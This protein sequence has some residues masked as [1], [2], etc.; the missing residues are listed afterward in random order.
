MKFK[1]KKKY[2]NMKM[3]DFL[4]EINKFIPN[5]IFPNYSGK[6]FL[7]DLKDYP[8]SNEICYR[9]LLKYPNESY[10][11]FFKISRGYPR[12]G[13]DDPQIKFIFDLFSKGSLMLYFENLF[14][15]LIS[16][17]RQPHPKEE[18]LIN[19]LKILSEK[20]VTDWDRIVSELG[21]CCYEFFCKEPEL[22]LDINDQ[23]EDDISK[24]NDFQLLQKTNFQF[25]LSLKEYPGHITRKSSR[26][27][28]IKFIKDKNLCMK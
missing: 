5:F 27:E 13:S 8:I 11:D 20:R 14:L 9:T 4:F 1:L 7:S 10:L 18:V 3:E 23:N 17:N 21:C 25:P 16:K 26:S 2:I 28:L 22:Y 19:Y 24:L 12:V 6:L 15:K